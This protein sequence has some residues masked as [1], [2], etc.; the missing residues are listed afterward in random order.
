MKSLL[1][2]KRKTTR[3]IFFL[4]TLLLLVSNA[5]L[6]IANSTPSIFEVMSHTEVL[7]LTIETNWRAFDD[8]R[9]SKT[10]YPAKI[11]FKDQ[12]GNSSNWLLKVRLRGNFRRMQCADIP[13][14]KLNFKKKALAAAGL[15]AFDDYKLVTHCITDK[16]KAKELVLREFL[17]YKLY[18]N[19]TDHSFRVQLLNITFKDTKTGETVQQ[20]G[21]LI[22]DTAEL[23][24]RIGAEKVEETYGLPSVSFY[25]D[26]VRRVAIFQYAIG[27]FDWRLSTGRNLKFVRKEDKILAIP[28]DFDFSVFVDAPYA[29]LNTNIGLKTKADRIYLGFEEALPNL[30]PMLASFKE[31]Q[32]ALLQIIREAKWLKGKT[33]KAL[34]K[35]LNSYFDNYQFIKWPVYQLA[36]DKIGD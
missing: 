30:T 26:Q 1:L 34:Q 3:L 24:N 23:R 17:A 28:Y 2:N 13:P 6:S 31:Q 25:E 19:L 33:R 32:P 5:T 35:Y 16:A 27:N 9:R 14:L 4:L 20:M 36:V 11:H 12:F 15:A 18:H 7:D 29:T 21:F 22:E 10:D 8:N